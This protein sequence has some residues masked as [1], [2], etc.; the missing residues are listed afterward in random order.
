MKTTTHKSKNSSSSTNKNKFPLTFQMNGLNTIIT[1]S[2]SNKKYYNLINNNSYN[3]YNYSPKNSLINLEKFIY[4][5]FKKTYS[6]DKDFYNIKVINE[7]ICNE[8]SHIVAIFK[9]YLINGD[10]SEFLQRFYKSYES[11]NNLPKIFEYYDSCSVIFPNYVV[12]PES[13]YIYKNIQRKQRVIDNQQELEEKQEQL[14]NQ[15]IKKH[16]NKK[17]KSYLSLSSSLT[18]ND[19]SSIDKVFNTQDI[20]S[21]LNQTN[22]SIL[23]KFFGIKKDNNKSLGEINNLIDAI[24]K[25]E[26]DCCSDR[27]LNKKIISLNLRK[28]TEISCSTKNSSG[29]NEKNHTIN[30][31]SLIRKKNEK[32][33]KEKNIIYN[34]DN[35]YNSKLDSK[36]NLYLN[37]NN[38]SLNSN[39]INTTNHKNNDNNNKHN[40]NQIE[41]K[42]KKNIFLNLKQNGINL[43]SNN[44]FNTN[45]IHKRN[46]S[47][48]IDIISIKKRK[49][50]SN[51][52]HQT[53]T[54]LNNISKK[55]S[56]IFLNNTH[57]RKNFSKTNLLNTILTS[58]SGKKIFIKSNNQ[59]S[60]K[61]IFNTMSN[62]NNLLNNHNHI[63]SNSSK[64]FLITSYH[65]KNALSMPKLNAENNNNNNFNSYNDNF[66]SN[67][68]CNSGRIEKNNNIIINNKKFPLS[69]RD[70]D[71]NFG[72]EIKNNNINNNKNNTSNNYYKNNNNK[73]I[74]NNKNNNNVTHNNKNKIYNNNNNDNKNFNSLSPKNKH[75]I[76]FDKI[77]K[78]HFKSNTNLNI[79]MNK[80]NN[81][82]NNNIPNKKNNFNIKGITIKGFDEILYKSNNSIY[83]SH[84]GSNN[85]IIK[86]S[87]NYK[88]IA[89]SERNINFK[90]NNNSNS[91]NNFN[92]NGNNIFG[93]ITSSKT[94]RNLYN[95][96][97]TPSSS[98]YYDVHIKKRKNYNQNK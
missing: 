89:N 81:Y 7:I 76:E 49:L 58:R 14:K 10:Y 6:N 55:S 69:H 90:S 67:I 22:H 68:N 11:Y 77:L 74:H 79:P 8:S 42:N 36:N 34:N 63:N 80:K 70:K 72:S 3:N 18:S 26:Y 25:A 50:N 82:N 24:D 20:D 9:D 21:I 19:S 48:I 91:N 64:N 12:L 78:T 23:N 29:K 65:V 59:S 71:R 17:K 15:Q 87:R 37:N 94:N 30:I 51:L 57:N 1:S 98:T 83:N 97:T 84:N 66:N 88:G 5:N 44:N 39:T 33:N 53:T 38:Y 47:S 16:K 52:I 4:K 60:S 28:N 35:F 27:N 46:I 43:N 86:T 2:S 62:Q 85:N 45:N 54:T 13:K 92:S 96:I 40:N 73:I 56:N 93:T 31:N 41:N 32:E 75:S 61:K 95:K